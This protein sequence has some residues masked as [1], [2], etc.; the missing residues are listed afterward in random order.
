[1]GYYIILYSKDELKKGLLL[2]I[3][4]EAKGQD[5]TAV[6]FEK[7]LTDKI[8]ITEKILEDSVSRETY[9][10]QPGIQL[11]V[12]GSNYKQGT[13]E[14]VVLLNDLDFQTHFL[15]PKSGLTNGLP[16]NLIWWAVSSVGVGKQSV[17]L[18]YG[19]NNGIPE[20]KNCSKTG[21]CKHNNKNL[22]NWLSL[23]KSIRL[24]Q[25]P[26]PCKS[27]TMSKAM[28]IAVMLNT[29]ELFP[30]QNTLLTRETLKM[31]I[32]AQFFLFGCLDQEDYADLLIDEMCRLKVIKQVKND[33]LG[34]YKLYGKKVFRLSKG[35]GVSQLTVD[36]DILFYLATN[37]WDSKLGQ[38]S[39]DPYY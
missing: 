14:Y 24:D 16:L 13:A 7:D 8:D 6:K 35:L 2:P 4:I 27:G 26:I 10:N 29:G 19:T 12:T 20:W 21:F 28:K 22:N 32:M 15:D 17:S 18:P 33:A 5:T 30:K 31:R 11:N 36:E 1:M 3:F 38:M 37:S 39:L 9:F 25:I 23:R 34:R